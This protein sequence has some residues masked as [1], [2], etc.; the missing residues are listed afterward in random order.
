MVQRE[1][2]D[3][4][5]YFKHLQTF[6]VNDYTADTPNCLKD[7]QPLTSKHSVMSTRQQ[8]RSNAGT[9]SMYA[10]GYG[11]MTLNKDSSFVNNRSTFKT[12]AYL[13]SQDRARE[14]NR[15]R[16]NQSVKTQLSPSRL[17]IED[18]IKISKD[19]PRL[20]RGKSY[21]NGSKRRNVPTKNNFMVPPSN[22]PANFVY[23]PAQ[24]QRSQTPILH[25]IKMK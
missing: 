24:G 22:L 19:A 11:E 7:H 2:V 4:Q 12:V 13:T 1:E 8:S 20:N 23:R 9:P 6:D 15:E 16:H 21:Q 3:D 18:Y 5:S 25:F 10:Y 17:C 14:G